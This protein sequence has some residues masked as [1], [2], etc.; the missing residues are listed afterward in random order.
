MYCSAAFFQKVAEHFNILQ[1]KLIHRIQG[2]KGKLTSMGIDEIFDQDNI[3]HIIWKYMTEDSGKTFVI[4]FCVI[5]FIKLCVSKNFHT[6]DSEC[7]LFKLLCHCNF[8][9]KHEL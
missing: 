1:V 8:L 5:F 9:F 4:F 6:P 2:A 7:Y 3:Q